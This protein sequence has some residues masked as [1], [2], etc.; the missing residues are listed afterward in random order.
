MYITKLSLKDFRN[1]SAQ[2]LELAPGTNLIYGQNAQGK[3]NILEAVA[4][5]SQG[6]SHRA[7]SDKELIRFGCDFARAAVEFKT[8]EREYQA[9]MTFARNGKKS[10][11]INNVAVKKLSM[12]MNYLNTVLFS[13]EDLSLVKGSPS[14][15]R[16][17]M[18]FAVS[19]L[20]PKYLV[21]LIDYNRA[22]NQKNSLLKTLKRSGKHSDVMLSVWN[23]QLSAEGARIMQYRLD[24]LELLR[25][26][27]ATVQQEI[28]GE[29]LEL[30]YVPGIKLENLTQ[31][32]FFE[33]LEKGQRREIEMQTAVYGI[34][35]DDVHIQINGND[36]KL[37]ASQGQQRTAALTLKIALSDY[38]RHIK[39]EYPVL[40]LDDIMSELDKS[41]RLY[42]AE[43]IRDKQVLITSTDTDILKSTDGTR[44][45]YVENGAV[46]PQ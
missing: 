27:A 2:T 9:V 11:K 6:K 22:L 34:Q 41:R 13:P 12:L 20:F 42:L 1:Y 8:A 26:F 17:F 10:I 16:K 5:F 19:Q 30:E 38:I 29:I 7:K 4:M 3:T 33:A 21:S 45:F 25:G 15:R 43:K 23:E 31:T 18:D 28:S 40:L 37:Y 46:F 39:D 36:A 24:F 35:R 14:V 32:D 44:L